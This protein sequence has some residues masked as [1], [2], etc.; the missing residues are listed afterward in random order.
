MRNVIIVPLTKMPFPD[1]IGPERWADWYRTCATAVALQ[2]AYESRGVGSEILVLTATRMK[3]V[4]DEWFY[5]ARA[6][7]QL[8]GKFRVVRKYY[9]T[10][11]QITGLLA[12]AKAEE[13]DLVIIATWLH[14]LRVLYLLRGTQAKLRIAF[15]IPNAVQATVDIFATVLYPLFDQAGILDPIVRFVKKV[16]RA[17]EYW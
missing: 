14:Y 2:R 16:R 13:K 17:H 8:G 7:R 11:E 12:M 5:Y 4:W 6:L 10:T 9:E 3:G 15:G 1:R